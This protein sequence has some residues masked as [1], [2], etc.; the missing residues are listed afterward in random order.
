MEGQRL[1]TNRYSEKCEVK[2]DTTDLQ[3]LV[4]DRGV[5]G[6]AYHTLSCL[7]NENSEK[8]KEKKM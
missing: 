6:N 3:S 4:E 7:R 5:Q 1:S 8:V 2:R